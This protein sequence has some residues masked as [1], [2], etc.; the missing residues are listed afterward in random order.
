MKFLSCIICLLVS[1][2]QFST[3]KHVLIDQQTLFDKLISEAPEGKVPYPFSE[4]IAYLSRYG[5]PL[6]VLVPLGRSLQRKAGYPHPFRDPR[7]LVTFNIVDNSKQLTEFNLRNLLYLAYVEGDKQIEVI[8]LLPGATKFDFQLVENYGN[9]TKIVTPEQSLCHACHQNAGPIFTPLP[10]GETNFNIANAYLIADHYPSGKIDGIDIHQ[11]DAT[12]FIFDQIVR[13][14]NSLVVDN[15]TWQGCAAVSNPVSCRRNLLQNTLAEVR[16]LANQVEVNVTIED[17]G[18]FLNDLALLNMISFN[19]GINDK[20]QDYQLTNEQY[21]LAELIASKEGK[22]T[23]I[24]PSSTAQLTI[25]IKYA[26]ALLYNKKSTIDLA[27]EHRLMIDKFT[28]NQR[29]ILNNLDNKQ[30]AL[31]R[32]SLRQILQHLHSKDLHLL[33]DSEL[34][35][36]KRI[37]QETSVVMT[38]FSHKFR[39]LLTRNK[40]II[41]ALYPLLTD[42]K[43]KTP[44]TGVNLLITKK[45]IAQV[46]KIGGPESGFF[47][48]IEQSVSGSCRNDRHCQL[49]G[50]RFF[51]DAPPAT[52]VWQASAS[53][54]ISKLTV[55]A[56]DNH[57]YL[58]F[59]CWN[60]H[61]RHYS[62]SIFD[63]DKVAQALKKIDDHLLTSPNFDEL[64]IIKQL[65]ANLGYQLPATAWKIPLTTNLIDHDHSQLNDQD[66]LQLSP[67]GQVMLKHCASCHANEATPA[68]F[69]RASNLKDFCGD[70]EYYRQLIHLR[71]ADDSMPPPNS[72]QRQS[73]TD[74]DRSSLLEATKKGLEICR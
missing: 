10:W 9:E 38:S 58:Q 22:T 74:N 60:S 45:G 8:S 49:K 70:F 59:K 20:W 23:L 13:E 61:A 44:I 6:A 35:P 66:G 67:T 14:A 5:K 17:F 27:L 25:V 50:V 18:S 34:D 41:D 4:L 31:L 24:D 51:E 30:Q 29:T 12:F 65:L 37:R 15:R 54:T 16:G 32:K 62:C 47:L 55:D 48:D 1:C 46:S 3:T 21:Q 28:D 42:N 39:R 2:K 19:D 33:K 36:Q 52:M 64:A 40:T 53:S 56:G 43:L 57:H 71:V 69:L 73:F 26:L 68:P 63:R 11:E 7:R 72:P